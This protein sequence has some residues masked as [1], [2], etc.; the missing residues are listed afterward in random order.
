MSFEQLLQE[1]TAV[2][3]DGHRAAIRDQLAV[4]WNR[5][6]HRL[7]NEATATLRGRSRGNGPKQTLD[8]IR[9]GTPADLADWFKERPALG[10]ILDWSP[11][12]TGPFPADFP[13]S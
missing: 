6:L 7:A 10:P 1:L 5:K 3:D 4:K 8:R 13:S 2:T 9:N 11:D 12:G